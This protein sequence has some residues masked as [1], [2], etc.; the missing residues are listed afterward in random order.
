[1]PATAATPHAVICENACIVDA[2]SGQL[3]PR[4]HGLVRGKPIPAI[5]TALTADSLGATV[6]RIRS[7][8]RTP[9]PVLTNKRWHVL[10]VGISVGA[11]IDGDPGHTT[12]V[13]AEQAEQALPRRSSSS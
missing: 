5:A 1:M 12:P 3:S 6:T 2:R 9:I 10:L 13:A 11:A 4:R 7:N 8:G